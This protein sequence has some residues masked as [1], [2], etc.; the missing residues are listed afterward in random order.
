MRLALMSVFPSVV[1]KPVANLYT[2]DEDSK[3]CI[4]GPGLGWT[5]SDLQK[6]RLSQYWEESAKAMKAEL[7]PLLERISQKEEEIVTLRDGV[8]FSS[9]HLVNATD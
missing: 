3:A 2:G 5:T 6:D 8:R 1:D 4:F 9:I 7:E